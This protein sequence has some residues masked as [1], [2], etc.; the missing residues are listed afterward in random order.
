M[1]THCLEIT[2]VLKLKN[3][4][5]CK[6]FILSLHNPTNLIILS[7]INLH[8]LSVQIKSWLLSVFVSLLNKNYETQ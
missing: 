2:K 7:C 1:Q 8:N 3:V 6:L 4:N 5:E